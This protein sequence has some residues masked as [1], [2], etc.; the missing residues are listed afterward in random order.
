[1]EKRPNKGAA[2]SVS[3]PEP[4]PCGLGVRSLIS[5]QPAVPAPVHRRMRFPR[6]Y[7]FGADLLLVS[8]AL[9]VLCKHPGPFTSVE[10]L[11]GVVAVVIGAGLAVIATCMRDPK[12]S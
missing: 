9:A 12:D 5:G 10:K 4:R 8:V 1:M 6:W 7:L 11:F 3:S 2:P